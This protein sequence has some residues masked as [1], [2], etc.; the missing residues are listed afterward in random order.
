MYVHHLHTRHGR[1]M[2]DTFCRLIAVT[3]RCAVAGALVVLRTCVRFSKTQQHDKSNSGG[4]CCVLHKN[5]RN[6]MRSVVALQF[7]P[8]KSYGLCEDVKVELRRH[9]VDLAND[10]VTVH[11]L[12]VDHRLCSI[13]C[14]AHSGGTHTHGSDDAKRRGCALGHAAGPSDAPNLTTTTGGWSSSRSL[15]DR[16]SVGLVARARGVVM[17]FRNSLRTD[18]R[19]AMLPLVA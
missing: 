14:G 4:A 10:L 13:R 5:A 12:G 1:M 8:F 2:T 7:D 19:D 9:R 18:A 16:S 11:R 3:N 6:R 17:R 15:C